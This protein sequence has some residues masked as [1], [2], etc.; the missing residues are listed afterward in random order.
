M[1][2]ADRFVISVESYYTV[3]GKIGAILESGTGKLAV[4]TSLVDHDKEWVV[5]NNNVTGD[6]PKNKTFYKLL[7]DNFWIQYHLDP[8][9]HNTIPVVGNKLEV[10]KPAANIGIA[11]SGA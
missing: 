11:K 8:I 4:G 2:L 1:E 5:T 9:G 10:K 6:N 3:S 7:K